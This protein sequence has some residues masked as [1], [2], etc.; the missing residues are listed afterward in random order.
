M[1]ASDLKK[2]LSV[3]ILPVYFLKGHDAYL[4]D[5][6]IKT[7][8]SLVGGDFADMNLSS[9]DDAENM[10]DI[11]TSL[12]TVPIF[13]DRR[14]V[15]VKSA[16][17][18]D[19]GDKSRLETY[20]KNPADFSVLVIRDD[21]VSDEDSDRT[22]SPLSPLYKYGDVV[23][24][25][26]ANLPQFCEWIKAYA[27][28]KGTVVT[29]EALKTLADYTSCNMARGII[30][31]DKLCAYAVNAPV[32]VGMVEELVSPDNEYKVFALS[33]ALTAGRNGEALKIMQTLLDKGE[34]AAALLNLLEGQ[35]RRML[36]ARISPLDTPSL[37]KAL[38]KS[39]GQMAV[40][41]K[42]AAPF[43]PVKLKD[44]V[45]RIVDLEYRFK[46]GEMDDVQALHEAFS[47]LINQK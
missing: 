45:D 43:T 44:A 7:L 18:L 2:R 27:A 41:K 39:Q 23:D 14:V 37:A 8:S 15:I 3:E 17:N 4:A 26:K 34:S 42:L 22:A 21:L 46:S 32:S 16:A 28:K 11:L 10:K 33:N 47:F 29:P 6:A 13:S 30:E 1:N 36:A 25:Q 24:C 9:Y 31:A 12:N 20:L 19:E 35:Y 38:G 5:W 40:S